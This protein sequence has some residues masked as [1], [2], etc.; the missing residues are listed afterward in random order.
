MLCESWVP[1]SL[2]SKLDMTL[3]TCCLI[4]GLSHL[5]MWVNKPVLRW[6]ALCGV[7]P[8]WERGSGPLLSS[9]LRPELAMCLGRSGNQAWLCAAQ[10]GS[11]LGRRQEAWVLIGASLQ[12]FLQ[13]LH[14][15]Q[16]LC[17]LISLSVQLKS[18]ILFFIIWI[19]KLR[20]RG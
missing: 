18:S 15:P 12:S 11:R 7:A 9:E 1:G 6:A 3:R 17:I 5:S 10:S 4:C 13:V 19:R 14:G 2:V 8:A 20:L 16:A